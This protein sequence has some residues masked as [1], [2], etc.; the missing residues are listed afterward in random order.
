MPDPTECRHCG[1]PITT[2][3]L[4]G[5]SVWTHD[6]DDRVIPH[7]TSPNGPRLCGLGDGSMAMPK[8]RE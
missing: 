1:H 5:V 6:R 4:G 8:E 2:V 7:L 3:T